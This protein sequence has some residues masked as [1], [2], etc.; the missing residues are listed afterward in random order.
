MPPDL[1][2]LL[3][4]TA[5]ADAFSPWGAP[6][7]SPT[8]ERLCREG[9]GWAAATSPAPWTVP[10]HAS[11]FSGLLPTEH[12]INGDCIEWTDRRPSSPAA[13]VR[14]F[15]GWWL[16]EALRE[17]GY[18]TW[19]ASCNS[20]ISTW[21]GFDRGFE[22]F[23]DL[24]PWAKP[25]R[26]AARYRY[27]ARKALGRMDR[28]GGEAVRQLR[29]RLQQAGP[30]P[31]FLF[32]NLMETHSP[33]DPPAPY[34]P[35]P[36]WRRLR[37]RHLAGGP[38]QGLSYNAGV[39][40]PGDRYARQLRAIYQGC[41]R[42][43][44]VVLGRLVEAVEERG[45]PSVV[46]VV[47]DHG[48][49]LGEHGLYNHNSSLHQTLLHVPMAAWGSGIDLG[50]GTVEEPASMARLGPWLVS[51]AD[52]GTEPMHG[53][54]AAISEYEGTHRHNGIPDYIR[55][56]IERSSP[57]VPPLVFNAGLAV[58]RGG[59]K[60]HV[61]S[62]GEQSVFDLQAD[63]GEERD[64]LPSRPDLALVFASDREAWERRRAGLPAYEAGAVAEGDIAEHL[65][66]LGY[67]E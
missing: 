30:E 35:F 9:L 37:T 28:G 62:S 55:T 56:G 6:H 63:P 7:P 11:M 23:L 47:A 12:G 21:G 25:K 33:F 18:R 13:A 67:I 26:T 66:E 14:G 41:A 5:R 53:E 17:R 36:F 3:C 1:V 51:L 4:D 38:D 54:P 57:R 19:G 43:E 45:R 32:V 16:P 8:L 39:V 46:I 64:L 52:G 24:R 10:S 50:Q 59:L 27:L 29:W 40:D 61:A 65:R 15:R 31:Q 34:Y 20:W 49:N 48:E 22:E 58:R 60:Y 2:L 44:D 42:Y